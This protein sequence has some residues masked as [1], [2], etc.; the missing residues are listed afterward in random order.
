MFLSHKLLTPVHQAHNLILIS[1]SYL[2]WFDPFSS[3][4]TILPYL[5]SE[6]SQKLRP[7]IICK[8]STAHFSIQLLCF[9]R[10][11]I[12]QRHLSWTWW[13]VD[14]FRIGQSLLL[15][16][17]LLLLLHSSLPEVHLLRRLFLLLVMVVSILTINVKCHVLT[18]IVSFSQ[19]N[20][21]DIT[22]F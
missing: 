13:G 5:I 12:Q 21:V 14:Q 10:P 8:N 2:L 18:M 6:R 3:F 22:K 11:M 15:L 4:L 17:V 1:I 7:I 9:R 20:A 16:L 19:F